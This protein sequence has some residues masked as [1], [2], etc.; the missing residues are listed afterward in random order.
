MTSP[1][2]PS[3]ATGK[4]GEGKFHDGQTIM[5]G[6]K[7]RGFLVIIAMELDSDQDTVIYLLKPLIRLSGQRS[8]DN[9]SL[10]GLQHR[11]GKAEVRQ[12]VKA[13]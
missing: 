2:I 5:T 4:A 6:E 11:A 1:W 12:K 9:A 10:P 3:G 13:G 7:S 8:R